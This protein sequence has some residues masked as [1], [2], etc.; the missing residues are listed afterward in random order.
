MTE[1]LSRYKAMSKK[2]SRAANLR[3]ERARN[4]YCITCGLPAAPYR[5]CERCRDRAFEKRRL[6]AI[7]EGRPE[8]ERYPKD[9]SMRAPREPR[10]F[11]DYRLHNKKWT[12]ELDAQLCDLLDK[13]RP[14]KEIAAALDCSL[15]ALERRGRTLGRKEF[16]PRDFSTPYAIERMK[17]W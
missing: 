10:E 3:K 12:P 8:P 9:S 1:Y 15:K 5:T 14:V 17:K 11:T 2:S 16:D 13:R 7:R 6:K 4:G